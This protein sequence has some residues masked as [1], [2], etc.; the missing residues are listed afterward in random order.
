MKII[1]FYELDKGNLRATFDVIIEE[2]GLTIKRCGY[3]IKGDNSWVG[4]PTQKYEDSDGTVKYS[5][6]V[7]MEKSRKGR[8]DKAVIAL[9]L[10]KT[11]ESAER[12]QESVHKAPESEET[13]CPF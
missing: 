9:I 11:Y 7:F 2:W 8:F 1:N 4:F 3:F 13:E 5:P 10:A 12:R 6:Y